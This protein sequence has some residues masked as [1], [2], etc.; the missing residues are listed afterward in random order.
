LANIPEIE[1]IEIKLMATYLTEIDMA[2]FGWTE[3]FFS[4]DY[5]QPSQKTEDEI[6]DDYLDLLYHERKEANNAP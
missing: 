2:K 4:K 3:K 5:L 1:K 6:G